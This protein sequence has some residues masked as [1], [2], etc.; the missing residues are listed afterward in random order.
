MLK[1]F[2]F[3]LALVAAPGKSW[4]IN[5]G[6]DAP[7]IE[8]IQF[9]PGGADLV[10]SILKRNPDSKYLVLEFFSTT[11]GYCIE[12]LPNLKALAE[13]FPRSVTFRLVGIDRREQAIRDFAQTYRQ[14]IIFD[15]AMDIKRE[16]ME[17]R[18]A[19]RAYAVRS[20]PTL[21]V[22]GEDNKVVL[23]RSGVLSADEMQSLRTL[24]SR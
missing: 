20:T 18:E 5:A 22:I 6:D 23:R 7:N 4:A 17:G 9:S 15:I 3:A 2:L 11:C 21:F 19:L 1:V 10:A 24:F 13:E 8:L 14:Y 16:G 12:N